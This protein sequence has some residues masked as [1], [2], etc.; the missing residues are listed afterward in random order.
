MPAFSTHYIFACEMLP[1]MKELADFQVN[2]DAVFIGTQGPDIFFFHR[3]FPWMPGKSYNKA[4]SA[5]HRA[6]PS[7]IL[8]AMREYCSS[9]DN[10][11]VAKSYVYGFILHYCLDRKCHP[12]VYSLQDKITKAHKH[13]NPH[14][15]HNTIEFSADSY[16]LD[17]RAGSKNQYLFKTSDVITSS[18][19]I[20]LEIGKAWEYIL[21]KSVGMNI[22]AKSASF[23]VG[24]TKR[25][26]K[27]LFDRYSIKQTA[28]YP[29]QTITAPILKN[30]KLT[31]M[32][33]PKDLEKAKK[34]VNINNERW[35]SP[36]SRQIFCDSFEEL[37]E[38]AIDDAK[39]MLFEFQ[40]GEDCR[41][42]TGNI[43]FLTGVEVK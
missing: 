36:F 29:I 3:V 14:S 22:T 20:S 34:Y 35:S 12:Y 16:L 30:F 43:S 4:G 31:S 23:A 17:K 5:L 39:T 15:V 2:D 38:K 8:S 26:Q 18:P 37:F 9:C 40:S 33:R 10:K 41:K 28:L 21:P 42:I 32:F 19:D 6:K 11:D 24:D 1:Y 7:V 13:A 27:I 25:A